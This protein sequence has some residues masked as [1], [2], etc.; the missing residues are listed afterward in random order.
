[1]SPTQEVQSTESKTYSYRS[2]FNFSGATQD[3]NE[4]AIEKF[5]RIDDAVSYGAKRGIPAMVRYM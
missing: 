4:N 3:N 1:M 2:L 5:E